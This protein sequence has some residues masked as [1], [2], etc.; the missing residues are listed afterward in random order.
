MGCSSSKGDPEI[1]TTRFRGA[2][3]HSHLE[4]RIGYF[5]DS[6]IF[7]KLT[8]KHLELMVLPWEYQRA[9]GVVV[10]ADP[11]TI[12][13]TFISHQWESPEHPFFDL[14]QITE[15]LDLIADPYFWC[16]WYSVP[17]WSRKALPHPQDPMSIT[18]FQMT[19]DFVLI[20]VPRLR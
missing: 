17:Q 16:D 19:A 5:C 14:K 4:V 1:F 18:I 12:A 6:A 8:T 20:F 15:H 13:Y 3:R 10:L 11:M 2:R 9:M 7:R